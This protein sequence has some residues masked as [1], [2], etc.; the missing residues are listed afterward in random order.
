MNQGATRPET[1]RDRAQQRALEED[2]ADSPLR[3][4]PLRQRLRNFSTDVG[5]TLLSLGGPLPYMRRLRDIE[6][7]EEEHTRRLAEARA[8]LAASG[9]G[10]FSEEWR[11]LA[12]RWVFDDINELID[13]HNRYFPIEARLPMD[14]RTGDFVTINGRSYRRKPLDARWILERFPA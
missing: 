9:N 14:P 11:A 7:L 13:D 12:A 4:R 8:E 1:T 6:A 5:A 2:L 10:Q 3:G